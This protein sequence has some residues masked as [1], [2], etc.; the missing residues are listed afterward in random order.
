MI[1][2]SEFGAG[3][4]TLFSSIFLCEPMPMIRTGPY[5]EEGGAEQE[6]IRHPILLPN[7]P[8]AEGKMP[9]GDTGLS[10]PSGHC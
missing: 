10:G 5:A 9:T 2:H 8:Q 3:E 1:H 6:D 4:G 7:V